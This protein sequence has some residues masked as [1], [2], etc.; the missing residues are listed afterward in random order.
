MNRNGQEAA[1]VGVTPPLTVR[2]PLGLIPDAPE[3]ETP[4]AGKGPLLEADDAT[5]F[6]T[7]D[8]LV[9]RQEQIAKNRLAQDKHWT[10]VKLGYQ[11]S[12]LTK[13]DN[14]DVYTQSYPP[15][16]ATGLRTGAVP[17]KQADLCQKLVETLMVDPPK[18]DPKADTDDE[19]A[20]RGADMAREFLTQDGD[21]SG[22]DD[23]TVFASQVDGATTRASTFNHY[24]VD[25]VGGG[26]MPK[27]IKAHPQAVDA[28]NPLVGPD[29]QPTTDYVTRYVTADG[30]FTENP[31][32]AER[33]WLPKQRID[34]LGR[35]HVRLIP[36]YQ[37]LH[38]AYAA[39]VIYYCTVADARR[40]WPDTFG[41][42][43]D[44]DMTPFCAWT[45]QRPA[46]ILPPMLRARWR[47]SR[48]AGS[49][50]GGAMDQRIMF[51]YRYVCLSSPEYP[52]G[53]DLYV[54]GANGGTVLSRETLAATVEVPSEDRQDQTVTDIKPM[55]L[56]LVQIRL[57][58]DV[59]DKDPTGVAVMRRVGGP[60]EALGTMTTAMLEAI[61]IVL[62]PARFATATSP[63][64][65]DDVESS[66]ATGDFAVVLS[67]DDMPVYEQPRELPGAFFN[68]AQMLDSGMDS[69]MGLNKPA[70]GSDNSKEVSGIAR[71]IAV[72]Q[73][74]VSL[75]RM[76]QAVQN[77]WA[78]HWRIKLQHA[79]KYFNQAQLLRY[80]GVD[81]SSKAEW[82]TG[83]DFARVGGVSVQPGTGTLMPPSEKVNYAIQL[84]D[85]GQMDADE[86][87]DVARPA[88]AK[89]LGVPENPHVQRIERQVSSWLEGPPEGWEAQA[90]QYQQAVAVHAEMTQAMFAAD[91]ALTPDQA[92][93]QPEAPW[94][95]FASEIMDAE[96]P[97]A[98]IRKRRLARL[99]AKTEFSKHPEPW[100][101][102]ARDAYTA[103]V[104]AI[105]AAAVA[106]APQASAPVAGPM[107]AEAGAEPQPVAG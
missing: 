54:S 107:S 64:T 72:E 50:R 34:K 20:Q 59:D 13:Q 22:T 74:L 91:P 55:D 95:P 23:V 36:E 99:M 35:E 60:G 45:P 44:D 25:K 2:G 39:V 77:A 10:A 61:D 87:A 49:E 106:S 73:S 75:S 38:D 51:W 4:F 90:A 1:G 5:V 29:G 42:M 105:Q 8:D 85:V 93:P 53:A 101:Q 9:L 78:R 33:V 80:T 84:R 47:E 82:F 81:G 7:V 69:S 103:A 68:M 11:F 65:S 94:T 37:D 41:E 40:R 89:Q 15:G 102:L 57:L 56:P 19:T 86:A 100:K 18:P 71:R 6:K 58:P 104:Q 26:A 70:Q 16:M 92:P 31:S 62:H 79:M 83:N 21:E 63:V 27:Q 76:Q 17:N 88:F 48:R 96:P 67:K 12:A 24:W 3:A 46:A 32:E 43:T 98:T 30:Q 97:I 52:E 66:R 28:S 14:Q